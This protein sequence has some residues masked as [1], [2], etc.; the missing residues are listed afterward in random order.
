MH[1]FEEYADLAAALEGE[2]AIKVATWWNTGHKVWRASVRR[3][4]PVFF[5]QDV[6]TSYYPDEEHMRQHVVASYRQEFR[7]MT[8]SSYN[9]EGLRALG[10][11]SVLVPPGIDLETFRPLEGARRREDM[12][13]ALGRSNPLKNFPLT[14]DAWRALGAGGPEL[15]LFGTEPEVAPE[16]R[17]RYLE[18]PSDGGVNALFN[19]C[20]VF[21]Q[22]ST[23]EGFCLPPLEAMAAGAAVVCTD[24]HGNRD[25]CVDGTNCLMPEQTVESV[26]GALRRLLRDAALRDRLGRAGLE[27][28]AEYAWEKRI[29]ELERFYEGLVQRSTLPAP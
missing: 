21:L 23:H 6:E 8:I 26:A 25:F 27:T 29:D 19:E 18:K 12:L 28:A 9:A 1:T 20:T 13:L 10:L 17:V 3:G 7:Y 16:G 14:V 11:S 24:A 4:I 15:T 22:T 5:V 2:R